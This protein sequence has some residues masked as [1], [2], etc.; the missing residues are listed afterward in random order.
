MPVIRRIILVV[1]FSFIFSL[2]FSRTVFAQYGYNS[3]T[4][5]AGC[6]TSPQ[7]LCGSCGA[8]SR[9]TITT[10]TDPNTGQVSNCNTGCALDTSCYPSNPC[11]AATGCSW[12]AANDCQGGS[13]GCGEVR[14]ATQWCPS[15]NGPVH[16]NDQ[17]LAN[18]SC[19]GGGCGS[20][21][22]VGPS[23]GDGT[24]NGTET[25]SSCPTDCGACPAGNA[26]ARGVV[27]T[28]AV[29]SCTQVNAAT[30]YLNS[31]ITLTP[32]ANPATLPASG[33]SY[34]SWT[35]L[36]VTNYTVADSVASG[37]VLKYACWT[38]DAPAAQGDSLIAG[39]V[40]KGTL[41]WNLGYTAG[42]PWIQTSGG[43]DVYGAV[44][45]FSNIPPG[46][47]P[48]YF[49]LNGSGTTPGVVTYGS[50]YDLCVFQM[51]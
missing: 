1:F 41:T 43:G 38:T 20:G 33:G 17:C 22:P 8:Y 28:K 39:V 25:C 7:G 18:A 31:S 19:G 11:A 16:C 44:N 4:G 47:T 21:P 45:V 49:S 10:C 14:V 37:Y 23:C 51:S 5:K 36:P 15:P 26:R 42:T 24:C 2:Q 50:A 32:N 13:C 6:V 9:T 29:N 40:D 12:T 3:C 46:A 27:I 35:N 30:N 34:A 48:R